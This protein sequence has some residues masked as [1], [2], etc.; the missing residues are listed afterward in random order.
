MVRALLSLAFVLLAVSMIPLHAQQGGYAS[1]VGLPPAS[2]ISGPV[3]RLPDGNIATNPPVTGQAPHVAPK[4]ATRAPEPQQVHAGR[5]EDPQVESTLGRETTPPTGPIHVA[6][7]HNAQGWVKG[8][9]YVVGARVNNGPAWN[10]STYTSGLRLDAFQVTVAGNGP[11]TDGPTHSNCAST[12]KLADGYSWK[13]LSQTDYVTITGWAYDAAVWMPNTTLNWY[14]RRRVPTGAGSQE[15]VLVAS[16]AS[17]A[18]CSR[19]NT[20]GCTCVTGA[21]PPHGTPPIT[22]DGTCNWGFGSGGYGSMP[23]SIG[24]DYPGYSSERGLAIPTKDIS[25]SACALTSYY[26]CAPGKEGAGTWVVMS[27]EYIGQVWNDREYSQANGEQFPLY[28]SAQ[29]GVNSGDD[30]TANYSTNNWILLTAAPG[31]SYQ[32][33]PASRTSPLAYNQALGAAIHDTAAGGTYGGPIYS[34]DVYF[35]ISRLQIKSDHNAALGF[36][37]ISEVSFSILDSAADPA[38]EANSVIT[39]SLV[40]GRGALVLGVADSLSLINDTVVGIPGKCVSG[41]Q[42]ANEQA[43]HGGNGGRDDP[44]IFNTAIFGCKVPAVWTSNTI[45]W[46][47][48]SG[49]NLT[50]ASNA[51]TG[52]V[53]M[54]S[55]GFIDCPSGGYTCTAKPVAGTTGNISINAAFVCGNLATCTTPDFRPK[56]GSPL[57][58]AGAD[59]GMMSYYSATTIRNIYPTQPWSTPDITGTARP[60]HG[61]FDVGAWQ[62]ASDNTPTTGRQ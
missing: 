47:V 57:I 39:N 36:L 59:A 14:D 29:T 9:R 44:I 7:I 25:P 17:V 2:T 13:W 45:D 51:D 8:A 35:N 21:T 27:G 52:A 11:S 54:H 48:R 62:T 3:V 46:N 18:S 56:A 12:C 20:A 1:H 32:D 38:F 34:T 10:G 23:V 42:F 50:D 16:P 49:H 40:I 15:Q 37:P 41:I 26:Y 28:F 19:A 60:Q 6:Q 33:N 58:G 22:G 43:A 30:P 4:S 55:P 24:A 53:T 61:H 5:P 31:E